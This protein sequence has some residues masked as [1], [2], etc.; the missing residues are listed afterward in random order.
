MEPYLEPTD[1]DAFLDFPKKER[2]PWAKDFVEC[3][4]CFGHGGWNLRTFS[5]TLPK[6]MEDNEENRHSHVHFRCF[7]QQCRGYGY[8]HPDNAK[9]IHNMVHF[10]NL[11]RCYNREKCTKCGM[12]QDIDS[13]D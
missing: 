8:T 12:T 13:S 11:G 6:G 7:C 5:Y 4:V 2:E 3:P 9:C 1:D 10:Q